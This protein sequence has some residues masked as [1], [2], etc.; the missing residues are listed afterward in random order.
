MNNPLP[1]HSALRKI[2]PAVLTAFGC[3]IV[4]L[5]IASVINENFLSPEYLLTSFRSPRSWP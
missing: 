4:L 2:D 5:L 3:I 1:A